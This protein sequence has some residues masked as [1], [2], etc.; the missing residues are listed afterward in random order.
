MIT[1]TITP[2][3]TLNI[4]DQFRALLAA[5][6]EVAVTNDLQGRVLITPIEQVRERLLE[7]FGMWAERDDAP[8]DGVS[9]MDEIRRGQR[10][11]VFERRPNETD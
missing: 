8:P 2:D 1:T 10:L 9:Y 7:T 6:Q 4:P 5:G 3:F 11:S